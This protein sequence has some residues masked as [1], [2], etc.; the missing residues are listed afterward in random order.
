MNEV[1]VVEKWNWF[2]VNEWLE[3]IECELNEWLILTALFEW[4]S[5]TEGEV[6]RELVLYGISVGVGRVHRVGIAFGLGQV[7]VN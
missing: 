5:P 4:L 7:K 2:K 3:L 6:M 1:V